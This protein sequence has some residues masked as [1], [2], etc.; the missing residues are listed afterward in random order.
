MPVQ[1]LLSASSSLFSSSSSPGPGPARQNTQSLSLSTTQSHHIHHHLILLH[2]GNQHYPHIYT[3]FIS[4]KRSFIQDD[5]LPWT[6]RPLFQLRYWA[7]MPVYIDFL[8]IECRLMLAKSDWCLLMMNE[9]DWFWSILIDAYGANWVFAKNIC[10][11]TLKLVS[12]LSQIKQMNSEEIRRNRNTKQVETVLLENIFFNIWNLAYFPTLTTSEI[13]FFFKSKLLL[14]TWPRSQSFGKGVSNIY[15][16]PNIYWISFKTWYNDTVAIYW[17]TC[18]TFDKEVAALQMFLHWIDLHCAYIE[19]L[20]NQKSHIE[21]KRKVAKIL[22]HTVQLLCQWKKRGGFCSA[23]DGWMDLHNLHGWICIM[24]K[25]SNSSYCTCWALEKITAN[26]K[27][28]NDV[29]FKLIFV[30]FPFWRKC[31]TKR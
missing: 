30:D 4:S 21:R 26:Y 25:L 7:F 16:L 2:H 19:D 31:C 28:S 5:A 22:P 8:W 10:L 6:Q 11:L 9:T 3:D 29:G 27:M 18:E 12:E 17:P 1:Y 20:S 14:C 13:C 15:W 24:Q 23:D